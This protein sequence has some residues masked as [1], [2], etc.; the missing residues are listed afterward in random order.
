[1]CHTWEVTVQMKF[2]YIAMPFHDLFKQH[3]AGRGKINSSRSCQRRPFRSKASG[4]RCAID[5]E[6][7]RLQFARA[8]MGDTKTLRQFWTFAIGR[9]RVA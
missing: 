2:V 9:E 4:F 8:L 3:L 7:R 1:M 5:Y 6:L